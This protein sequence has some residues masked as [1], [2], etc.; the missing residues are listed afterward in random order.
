[1]PKQ[2][3]RPWIVALVILMAISSTS[4]VAAG[5]PSTQ[6]LEYRCEVFRFFDEVRGGVFAHDPIDAEAGGVDVS[7]EILSSRLS[8]NT[9][10]PLLDLAFSPRLNVGA[11]AITSGTTSYL[12]AGLVWTVPLFERAF[13]E[14]AF[15][16]ALNNGELD[17]KP[18]RAAMGCHLTFR[19]AFGLGHELSEQ[20]T[21]IESIEHVSHVNLCGDR[22]SGL[23]NSGVRIGYRF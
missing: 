23:T 1:M 6:S 2:V 4:R 5:D 22:N 16:A 14:G 11:M 10:N 12:Y 3:R 20:V 9:G 18:G 21:V 17:F 13:A 7:V 15:G 8:V 19:E